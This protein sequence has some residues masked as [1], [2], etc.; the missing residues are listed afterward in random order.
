[1]SL[2]KLQKSIRLVIEEHQNLDGSRG[3]AEGS[4]GQQIAIIDEYNYRGAEEC[5]RGAAYSSRGTANGSIEAVEGVRGAGE[6]S[7]VA[8][9]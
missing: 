8:V 1:M 5:S 6:G 4:K 9:Q 7:R 2:Q 3:T